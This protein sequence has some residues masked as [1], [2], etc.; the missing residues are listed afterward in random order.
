MIRDH[1]KRNGCHNLLRSSPNLSLCRYRCKSDF[2]NAVLLRPVSA[3]TA[4]CTRDPSLCHRRRKRRAAPSSPPRFRLPDQRLLPQALSEHR[5]P[6]RI[7]RRKV[8]AHLHLLH[9]VNCSPYNAS[10]NL[11]RAVCACSAIL[12]NVSNS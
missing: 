12:C 3:W 4:G 10:I 11:E 5:P 9:E 1:I 2:K 7:L 8:E 6:G